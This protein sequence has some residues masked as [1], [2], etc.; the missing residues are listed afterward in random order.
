MI[1]FAAARRNMVDT[2]LRTCDVTSHKVLD[3]IERVPREMFVPAALRELAYTDQ[4]VT[5]DAGGGATRTLLPM[6]VLA[7][8]LQA[9]EVDPGMRVL[10]CAGGS[11]Y[12]AALAAALGGAVTALEETE[13]MANL[14]RRT[15]ASCAVENV[16]VVCGDLAAGYAAG[17]PYDAIVV[18][19]AADCEPAGVLS[20]LADG[21]R[22][23]VVMGRG[24]SGRV[25]LFTRSGKSVGKRNILDGAAAP[26][27]AFRPVAEFQ[28]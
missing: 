7:R 21:G 13:A 27:A 19:G 22:L 8:M 16:N 23:A 6:V 4:T 1:D 25:V 28:F 9:V 18:H 26:L 5:V 20:Q 14:M 24:R 2:Q 17:G 10:D 15:L 3:A 12:G 11:G